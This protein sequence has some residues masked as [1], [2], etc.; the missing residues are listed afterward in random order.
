M[1][2]ENISQQI[3]GYCVKCKKKQIMV[4]PNEIEMKGKGGSKRRALTSNCQACG[5]KLFRIMPK[6]KKEGS[7]LAGEISD[8]DKE[9]QLK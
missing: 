9:S 5:T 2:K 7:N 1:D 8:F 3:E 4:N 6:E